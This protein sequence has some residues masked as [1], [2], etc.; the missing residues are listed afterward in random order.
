MI[1]LKGRP[2]EN[3]E[4]LE[5]MYIDVCSIQEVRW[6]EISTRFLTVKRHKYKVFWVENSDGVG[7]VG[8]LLAET[9]VD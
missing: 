7:S 6:R 8:I 2:G 5:R 9:W 4:I 1:T 3:V